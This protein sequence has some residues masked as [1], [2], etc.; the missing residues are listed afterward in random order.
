MIWNPMQGT[1]SQG[2]RAQ[3]QHLSAKTALLP[4]LDPFLQTK[5][6]VKFYSKVEFDLSHQSCDLFKALRLVKFLCRVEFQAEHSS[7]DWVCYDQYI[8]NTTH[9]IIFNDL[10]S[11]A[12]LYNSSNLTNL[13]QF[14]KFFH[15]FQP[16]YFDQFISTSSQLQL[17][18]VRLG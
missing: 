3:P 10:A 8:E 17:E 2:L 5:F 7:Q 16:V 13:Q 14:I 18:L 12:F 4:D 9:R 1:P 15:D 6:S 11:N